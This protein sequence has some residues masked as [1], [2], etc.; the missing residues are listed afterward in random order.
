MYSYKID[1]LEQWS[2][3][4][5]RMKAAGYVRWTLQYG[6]DRPE[7]FHAFFWSSGKDD[8]EIITYDRLVH[9]AI[10]GYRKD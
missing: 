1:N 10:M 8:V 7:G 6:L 2:R 9:D 3:I 4:S 5:T